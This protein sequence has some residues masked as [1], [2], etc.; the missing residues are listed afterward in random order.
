MRGDDGMERMKRAAVIGAGLGG[1]A[2]A[3][4]LQAAGVATT[5]IEARDRPGGL[6]SA[7]ERQGFTFDGGPATLTNPDC[8]RELWAL[9]GHDLARDVTLLPVSPFRRLMWPDGT[10]FDHSDDDA[11][12]M[13][14][15][16][17]LSPEDAGGYRRFLAYS[18]AVWRDVRAELG[19]VAFQDL[20]RMAK[21][22]P[23]LARHRAWRSLHAM[24]SSFVKDT[25][26]RE[27][28]SVHV[29]LMGGDPTTIS[30]IHAFSHQMEHD[31]GVWYPRGGMGALVA[32]MVRQFERLGGALM[33]GDPAVEIET[34][35]DRVTGVRAA[36]GWRADFDAVASNADV[37]H[38]LGGL[39]GHTLRGRVMAGRLARKRFAPSVFV[40][41]FG[42][43][44]IWPGIP[45]HSVLFGP[46]HAGLLRDIHDHGVL[47]A[48]LLLHLHHPSVTD[49]AMA[50]EGMSTFS[51]VA[52]VPHLGKLPIDWDQEGEAYADR[53]LDHVEARL[54]HGLRDR[55]VLRFH[56]TPADI[57]RD[58]SAHLG[59]A[60]GLEPL[61][62]QSAWLRVHNRDDAIPNLY[63][64]GAG[65][66]PGA[67]VPGVV[68]S[69]K[70][71]ARLMLE[72][73]RQ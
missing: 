44:G 16:G 58:L 26:L 64:V 48:D 28:L 30:A 55:L 57:G 56:M 53:I 49:P 34:R 45:H 40:A 31:G 62:R 63:F 12:L 35:G 47:P 1:L 43:E 7:H 71:T 41:H 22:A 72:E 33:L 15:I 61:L 69:A 42:I 6:A 51:A 24:I 19:P 20:T 9:G 11:A 23:V 14:E 3:I 27:A 73:G 36:S 38:T 2:L 39:L 60:F 59:S 4:R 52:L 67:G 29:L 50:P 32:A 65:T 13:R 25:H 54:I 5:V 18:A 8:L 21:A 70:V 10:R 37:V 66:H 17:G 46:R 68:A